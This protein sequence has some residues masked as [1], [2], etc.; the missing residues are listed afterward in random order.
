MSDQ[1]LIGK[2]FAELNQIR[3]NPKLDSQDCLTELEDCIDKHLTLYE[4]M[5]GAFYRDKGKL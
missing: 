3:Y 1:F 2:F 5:L 4:E